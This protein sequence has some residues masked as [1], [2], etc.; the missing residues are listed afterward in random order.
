MEAGYL[1]KFVIDDNYSRFGKYIKTRPSIDNPQHIKK[2][3]K[4]EAKKK[5]KEKDKEE[6]L[7]TI[8]TWSL[9]RFLRPFHDSWFYY[10]MPSKKTGNL[11]S[12]DVM[13]EIN[14]DYCYDFEYEPEEKDILVIRYDYRNSQVKG[15]PRPYISEYLLFV[16]KGQKWEEDN[17][18]MNHY[19]DLYDG[20][21]YITPK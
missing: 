15:W 2:R 13:H 4:A 6:Y 11:L 17:F 16:F 3:D 9:R 7:D 8:Y 5:Q 19:E 12:A 20:I 21:L 18:M 10:N 1:L 14:T